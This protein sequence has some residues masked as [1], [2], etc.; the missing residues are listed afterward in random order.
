[1]DSFW[2]TQISRTARNLPSELFRVCTFRTSTAILWGNKYTTMWV[3]SW[4]T[5]A[6]HGK[7]LQQLQPNQ[8]EGR[9]NPHTYR[10]ITNKN[11]SDSLVEE[12]DQIAGIPS[13]FIMSVHFRL[14]FIASK[15]ECICLWRCLSFPAISHCISD[16]SP[17]DGVIRFQLYHIAILRRAE[18]NCLK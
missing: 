16:K 1:M 14:H 10:Q 11:S 8:I 7:R 9:K 2:S 18:R 6:S 3:I 4:N 12:K 15:H 13:G 5:Y 17:S